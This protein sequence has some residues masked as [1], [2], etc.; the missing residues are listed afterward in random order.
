MA[1]TIHAADTQHWAGKALSPS[2]ERWLKRAIGAALKRDRSSL[3]KEQIQ[4]EGSS[5]T[6]S[7]F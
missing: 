4:V 1:S 6:A 5:G 7:V 2:N 3:P